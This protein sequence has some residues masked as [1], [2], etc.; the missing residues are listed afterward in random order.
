VGDHLVLPINHGFQLI[1][2]PDQEAAI[3]LLWLLQHETQ[4]GIVAFVLQAR[5]PSSPALEADAACF[6]HA[7]AVEG[8]IGSAGQGLGQHRI[9]MVSNP[10]DTCRFGILVQSVFREAIALPQGGKGYTALLFLRLGNGTCRLPGGIGSHASQPFLPFG[11][12]SIVEGSA[13]LQVPAQAFGLPVIHDLGQFQQERGRCAPWLC[14]RL[15]VLLLLAHTTAVYS[16]CFSNASSIHFLS[17]L[18]GTAVHPLDES[19]GLSRSFFCKGIDKNFVTNMVGE[20]I[21][22]GVSQEPR[23]NHLGIL[24]QNRRMA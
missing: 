15:L 3:A 23:Y 17:P 11:K 5:E 14:F 9:E 12:H 19:Q 13:R 4:S 10:A 21:S 22:C 16:F 6:S 20:E 1:L 2:L 24:L 8:A 18:K 7:D